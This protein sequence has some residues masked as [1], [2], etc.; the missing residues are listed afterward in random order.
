[1][2]KNSK[3]RDLKDFLIDISYSIELI[4]KFVAGFDFEKFKQD[5]K[6]KDAV[7]MRI[8]IIGE[9]VNNLP[10][11]F[12]K[13]HKEIPWQGIADMRNKLIH[14]YFGINS[15]VV[16]KT[17]KE[18]VP[19]LKEEMLKLLRELNIETKNSRLI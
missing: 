5:E 12:K 14:E 16:W 15:E 6:T 18:D 13:D 7:V 1:M 11:K 10:K 4:E 3:K 2:R 19:G 9:A 8:G 17:V